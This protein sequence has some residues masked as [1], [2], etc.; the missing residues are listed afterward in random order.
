[1]DV[2]SEVH[3]LAAREQA[4][5][6]ASQADTPFSRRLALRLGH[7]AIH[8]PLGPRRAPRCENFVVREI[9]RERLAAIR[10]VFYQALQAVKESSTIRIFRSV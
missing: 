3:W 7:E 9:L 5:P 1:M 2:S 4:L 8:A 10:G 6:T